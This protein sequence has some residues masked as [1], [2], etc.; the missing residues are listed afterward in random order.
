MEDKLCIFFYLYLDWDLPYVAI[1]EFIKAIA[2]EVYPNKVVCID[3]PGDAVVDLLKNR[4]RLLASLSSKNLRYITDNLILF[5]PFYF[6]NDYVGSYLP[7][8]NQWQCLWL[9]MMLRQMDLF[10]KEEK[11]ISWLFSSI[12]WPFAELFPSASVV[13]HPLDE[14]TLTFDGRP[15]RRGM[16]NEKRMLKKCDLVFTVNAELAQKRRNL[17]N[18][19]HCLGGWGVDVDHFA[20]ALVPDISIPQEINR[21]PRPRIGLVGNLRS[22]IDF[23]LVEK[24]LQSRPDWSMIFIGPKD[25]SA[26]ASIEGLEK[27]KNF[28]WLGPKP[29]EDLYRWLAGLDVGIIP[30]QETQYTRFVNPYKI[31]EYWAAGLP[32]VTTRIGGFELR[33]N[34]LWVSDTSETF[35]DN[36]ERALNSMEPSATAQ[37]LEVAREHSWDGIAKKALEILGVTH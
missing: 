14:Y 13:Y 8:V 28:F 32:V 30:Y 36:I 4:N 18:Q 19:V 24:V 7:G 22:W 17:H 2:R 25:A 21:I 9:K 33:P 3:R 23:V 5:R 15:N 12:H 27:Y 29:Y 11:I 37:R 35:I 16:V 34:C 31:Y 20:K 10:P 26:A 6:L 1:R